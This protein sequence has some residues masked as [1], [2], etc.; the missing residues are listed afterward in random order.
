[1]VATGSRAQPITTT[2]KTTSLRTPGMYTGRMTLATL[3]DVLAWL[4]ATR[5]ELLEVIVQ[6]E[7]THDVVCR[8]ADGYLVFDTT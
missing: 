4:S 6:D 5:G 3:E 7:Y 2:E 1:M 8:L